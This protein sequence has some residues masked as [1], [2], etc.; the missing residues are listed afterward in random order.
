MI[1]RTIEVPDYVW[2]E[3]GK[4]LSTEYLTPQKREQSIQRVYRLAA[5]A[6]KDFEVGRA[7]WEIN[8]GQ[9]RSVYCEEPLGLECV[10]NLFYVYGEERGRRSAY[11]I[12]E[13]DHLAAK[14]FVWIVSKGTRE[15]DWGL[16]LEMV[17]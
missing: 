6:L 1:K 15:I 3:F 4:P 13:S 11:A 12:F 9:Y 7:Q 5:H 16:F 8:D 2:A 10:D 17:P 14:Y